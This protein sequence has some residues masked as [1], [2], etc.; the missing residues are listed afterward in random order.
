M[1]Y[2]S[3]VYNALITH[4]GQY[5]HSYSMST[6]SIGYHQPN[7]FDMCGSLSMSR[8][9]QPF[10]FVQQKQEKGR[11]RFLW[12]QKDMNICCR[13]LWGDLKRTNLYLTS[14]RVESSSSSFSSLRGA[15]S[16]RS[17]GVVIISYF[18]VFLIRLPDLWEG[19]SVP[20][21]RGAQEMNSQH[22]GWLSLQLQL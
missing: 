9:L 21:M 13:T 4:S 18:R 14:K 5:V 11:K 3:V 6:E 17:A 8:G 19:K 10:L 1:V 22:S 2:Y 16:T 15:I 7:F 12:S 20:H